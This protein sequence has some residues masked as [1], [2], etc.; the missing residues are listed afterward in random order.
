MPLVVVVMQEQDAMNHP[1]VL[2]RCVQ[3]VLVVVWKGEGNNGTLYLVIIQGRYTHRLHAQ[4][5]KQ[6]GHFLVLVT[7]GSNSLRG[8]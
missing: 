4:G 6:K 8:A 5:V 2:V 7:R 1:K 3:D